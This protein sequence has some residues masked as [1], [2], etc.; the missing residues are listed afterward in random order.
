MAYNDLHTSFIT[1]KN[2]LTILQ[3]GKTTFWAADLGLSG[4]AINA[5]AN[6][7]FITETGVTKEAF[8]KI[9]SWR[10]GEPLYKK[11]TAKQ[12]RVRN[13]DEWS[14]KCLIEDINA[15]ADLVNGYNAL[16]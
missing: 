5:L 16:V 13:L 15:L 6:Y 14:A 3:S 8:I 9:N 4:G 12:W 1:L 7:R 10:G 11:V 2:Y